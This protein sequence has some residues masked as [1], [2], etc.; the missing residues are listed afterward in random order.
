MKNFIIKNKG[1][2]LFALAIA[3]VIAFV[4]VYF[5]VNLPK[6][7]A[8]EK[9]EEEIK[10]SVEEVPEGY[11]GIYDADGLRN[12]ENNVAGKYILMVDLDMTG[13]EFTPIGIAWEKRFTGTLEGNYHTIS[14]LTINSDNEY[15]GMF[16]NINGGTVQNLTLENVNVKSTYKSTNS[17][18]GT[19]CGHMGNGN[20]DNIRIIGIGKIESAKEAYSHSI[21]GIIGGFSNGSISN[22]Y[23]TIDIDASA[24]TIYVGG[25]VG[26]GSAT[27][28]YNCYTTGKFTA[29][30]KNSSVGGIAGS[31]SSTITN[32]YAT[33]LIVGNDY[34][35]G[36]IGSS[37]GVIINNCYT[38]GNVTGVRGVGGLVGEIT[39]SDKSEIRNS[40]AM[41]TVTG[42]NSVGGLVGSADRT[43]IDNTYATGTVTGTNS[44]GGLVG[45]LYNTI[46]VNNS[47]NSSISN[48]HAIGEVIG[49]GDSIN[50][51]GLVGF[52]GSSGL[53][54]NYDVGTI[55]N[56]YAIGDVTGTNRVGGLVGSSNNDLKINTS[57]SKGNVIGTT[58]VGGL[59]GSVS[60]SGGNTTN[61][62]YA[63]GS[64]TGDDK[65]GGLVGYFSSASIT[66]KNS[67]AIGK[68]KAKSG[69]AGGLIGVKKYDNVTITNSY[70]SPKLTGC[71]E[72]AGGTAKGVQEL[73]YQDAYEGWVFD[74]NTW[75]IEPE[76]G[77]LAYL[78]IFGLPEEV[79]REEVDY[80]TRVGLT[81][82]GTDGAILT[83]GRYQVK[84]S[85]GEIVRQGGTN[86]KGIFWIKDLSVGTYTV[87][88]TET[89]AGYAEDKT[90]YTFKMTEEGIAVDVETN[91][92]ITLQ[93]ETA[94]LTIEIQS[95]DDVTE[96]GL[97]GIT[98]GLY[99]EDGTEVLGEDGT[100]LTA[101]TNEEGKISFSKVNPGTYKYKQTTVK[102]KYRENYTEY[103]VT[104]AKDGS[105]TY[106]EE[107]AGIIYNEKIRADVTI[108]IKDGETD[109]PLQGAIIGIY[110][111]NKNPIIGE[112][113]NQIQKTTN[114]NGQVTFEKLE[115]GTYY[116]EEIEAPEGYNR[117]ENKY[118][119][120]VNEDGTVTFYGPDGNE[121][122][123]GGTIGNE[124]ETGTVIIRKRY[125]NG[126][127]TYPL[128]GAVI[129]LYD[130]E[131]RKILDSEGNHIK[132]TT[133]RNGQAVFA[134]LQAGTYQYR[135]IVAPSGFKVNQK[136]Y[137]FAL[138]EGGVV[139]HIT[140]NNGTI[141]NEYATGGII[142]DV[143]IETGREEGTGV[144]LYDKDGNKIYDE[145]G[146]PVTIITD[147][148]GNGTFSGLE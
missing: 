73:L 99:N 113:G 85:A 144:H 79:T 125:T 8:I 6:K 68:T 56:C 102:P 40:Y 92:E 67:Y 48:S 12:I 133:N 108:T 65:V 54:G 121:T 98:I 27:T 81:R 64:V 94:P 120:V 86:S 1:K 82:K 22:S 28:I 118:K 21:G 41:G 44:V 60:S 95:R 111:G 74:E 117:D 72:S 137:K 109:E 24:T 93:I 80:E 66:L 3:I 16:A 63:L 10:A 42:S 104:V 15:V 139:S 23:T 128:E 115:P 107:N 110:D 146:D 132:R 17:S 7:I 91:E 57:Y 4:S 143:P 2:I 148:N 123:N 75:A 20:I 9:N 138:S 124:V 50:I 69:T 103:T 37:S 127:E 126:G 70:Y 97:Q 45:R 13:E 59:I 39:K 100:P 29:N 145:N 140:N 135:E 51:G 83:D 89:P 130:L 34:A 26:K 62:T 32:C 53:N 141:Y 11:I 142:K 147:G 90:V 35:G 87:E 55:S 61:N 131:G 78:K 122:T 101:V 116:Y 105:L 77:S 47:N 19:L 49:I 106:V 52:T 88:E 96:E 14:N 36:L 43:I 25:I 71:E 112:D 134:G 38:T 46:Y 119:F 114:E 5:I 31:Y 30:G 18:I 76:G 129:G 58:E 33:G 136:M 84:N